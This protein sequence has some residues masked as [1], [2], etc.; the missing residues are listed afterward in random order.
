M[1]LKPGWYVLRYESEDNG[2]NFYGGDF[3]SQE[4]ADPVA[5]GWRQDFP[6]AGFLVVYYPGEG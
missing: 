2:W 5:Q 4:V 1:N 3:P 6:E